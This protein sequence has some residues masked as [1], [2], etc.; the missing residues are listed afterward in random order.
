MVKG[1][2]GRFNLN[3]IGDVIVNVANNNIEKMYVSSFKAISKFKSES[4]DYLSDDQLIKVVNSQGFGK[5]SQSLGKKE[6]QRLQ[7][8]IAEN[9]KT[10]QILKQD[11]K[12]SEA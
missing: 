5:R 7:Q 6:A 9:E 8:I 2:L 1:Y 12:V 10:N 11:E 3:E 4:I